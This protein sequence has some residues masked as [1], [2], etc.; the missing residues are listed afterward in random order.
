[1]IRRAE[2]QGQRPINVE[3]YQT[4]FDKLFKL[5][6]ALFPTG[7]P[8]PAEKDPPPHWVYPGPPECEPPDIDYRQYIE[9]AI[10][11]GTFAACGAMGLVR[12]MVETQECEV[13]F[14]SW[15]GASDGPLGGYVSWLFSDK[16][17][18]SLAIRYDP[19]RIQKV[20]GS[21]FDMNARL[22]MTFLHEAGHVVLHLSKFLERRADPAAG[23]MVGLDPVHEEEAWFFASM[24]RGIFTGSHA[25]ATR[26]YE[27]SD[28]GWLVIV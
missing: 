4:V 25:V 18:K 11:T 24:V 17:G 19:N 15:P 2:Q 23:E 6:Q 16:T 9:T 7:V 8:G 13:E 12:R 5:F 21:T 14:V 1:M 28:K 10:N 27:R 26:Y 3:A 22:E 20:G